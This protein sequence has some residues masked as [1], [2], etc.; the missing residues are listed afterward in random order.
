MWSI[1]WDQFVR[2]ERHAFCVDIV[3]NR[4]ENVAGVIIQVILDASM[5]SEVAA[6]Q[7][8]SQS[9]NLADIHERLKAHDHHHRTHSSS[10]ANKLQI[11]LS[12]LR[13]LLDILKSDSV[14]IVDKV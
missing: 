7:T 6:D 11:D 13:K 5:S 3:R 8:Q 9:L 10:N 1:G 12:T 14:G 4:M 2:E